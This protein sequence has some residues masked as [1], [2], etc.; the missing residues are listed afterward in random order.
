MSRHR[1]GTRGTKHN[2]DIKCVNCYRVLQRVP[3]QLNFG[4]ASREVGEGF[5]FHPFFQV[6]LCSSRLAEVSPCSLG[7]RG[8]GRGDILDTSCPDGCG[9]LVSWKALMFF[10]SFF[11]FFFSPGVPQDHR[12]A[13]PRF[14]STTSRPLTHTLN[15]N[16]V[17]R[18]SFHAGRHANPKMLSGR[19]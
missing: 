2:K 17:C 9:A 16:W 1:H 5:P 6:H 3:Q 8:G 11:L 13:L 12:A 15:D 4:S 19:S 7:S 10:P 14:L 18:R